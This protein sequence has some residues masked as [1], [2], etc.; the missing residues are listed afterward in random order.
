MISQKLTQLNWPAANLGLNIYFDLDR[1]PLRGLQSC[2][3]LGGSE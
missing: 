1:R 3:R 2:V